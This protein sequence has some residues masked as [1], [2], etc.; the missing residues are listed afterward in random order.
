LS[1]HQMPIRP[2]PETRTEMPP[3]RGRSETV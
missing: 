1:K 3:V 2:R